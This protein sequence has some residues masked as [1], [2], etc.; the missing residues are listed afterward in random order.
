[1]FTKTR[2]WI[3]YSSFWWWE[4]KGQ[5]RCD[6]IK[7]VHHDSTKLWKDDI[8]YLKGQLHNFLQHQ[9]LKHPLLSWLQPGVV[10]ESAFL[11]KHVNTIKEF[12]PENQFYLF[13]VVSQIQTLPRGLHNL[14]RKGH[15]IR[16]TWLLD[17]DI[18]L[19]D[20]NHSWYKTWNIMIWHR[21][22]VCFGEWDKTFLL[23][24]HFHSWVPDC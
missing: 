19:Q 24:S 17:G 5:Y 8:S 9:C 21:L 6:L 1:M 15:A 18:R 11:A 2:G 3:D 12:D 13:V 14:Y 23:L 10:S 16:S 4:V 20:R 22:S 7:S